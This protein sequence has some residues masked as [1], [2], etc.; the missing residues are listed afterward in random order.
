[1]SAGK[2][3]S[4][5]CPQTRGTRLVFRNLREINSIAE[6]ES[7]AGRK[8]LK[9]TSLFCCIGV[10]EDELVAPRSVRAR[11]KHSTS[12][13]NQKQFTGQSMQEIKPQ[14][15]HPRIPSS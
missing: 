12:A 5:A 8:R 11:A 1:M 7:L 14:Q 4:T 2:S 15:S 3:G 6:Q 9:A 13:L 10:A